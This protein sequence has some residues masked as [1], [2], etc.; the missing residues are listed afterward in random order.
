MCFSSGSKPAAKPAPAP[1][2]PLPA[3][4]D[5]EIGSTR[6][7]ENKENFGDQDAPNYRVSRN[8][9]PSVAPSGPIQM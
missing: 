5:P 9:K 3:P 4:D 8:K 2:A 1:D 7:R 6:R